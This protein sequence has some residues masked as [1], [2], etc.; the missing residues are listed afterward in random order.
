M[1]MGLYLKSKKMAAVIT[2]SGA[3]ILNTLAPLTEAFTSKI[4]LLELMTNRSAI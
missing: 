1:A 3:A 4:P 2:T